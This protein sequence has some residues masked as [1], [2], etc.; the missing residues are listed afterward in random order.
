MSQSTADHGYRA[1]VLALLMRH[2]LGIDVARA[3]LRLGQELRAT[4]LQAAKRRR[5]EYAGML[6][7]ET[8]EEYGPRCEGVNDRVDIR[9]QLHAASGRAVVSIHTHPGSSAF[10]DRDAQVFLSAPTIHVLAV[11]GADGTWYVL[12]D[13]PAVKRDPAPLVH[14]VT[15]LYKAA[16][17][18][19]DE[20]YRALKRIGQLTSERAWQ[21]QTH[22]VWEQLGPALGLRY[23]RVRPPEPPQRP[24]PAPRTSR[25]SR[26]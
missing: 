11:I 1:R 13:D 6:D 2:G 21:E 20:T 16:A 23:D 5:K 18:G 3:A 9:P 24:K 7:V 19:R 22:D 15:A 8:G 17:D 26:P 12:S 25:P 4:T 10:S 14:Q